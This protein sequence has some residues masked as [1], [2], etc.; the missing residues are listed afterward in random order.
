VA[1]Q[2]PDGG[3]GK[4]IDWL[5]D[6]EPARILELAG[7]RAERSTFDNRN[8]YTQVAYLAEAYRR[9]GEASFRESAERGLGYILREQRPSGGWRGSDIE[10]ITYNDDVMSGI[11]NLLI[12][13]RQGDARFVWLD[14]N[15]RADA[16]DALDRAV[17]VTLACQIRVDGRRTAWCQQHDHETLDAIGARTFELRGISGAESVGIVRTLMR[18]DPS[19]AEVVEAVRAAVAWFRDAALHGIRVES[20]P[21]P[22][23]VLP[24]HTARADKVVVEDPDAPPLWARFYDIE[25]NRPFFADRDGV[26][27]DRLDAIGLERRTGYAWYG[28][29]PGK[30]LDEEYPA[31]EAR[32]GL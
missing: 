11:M 8:V 28:R 27:V 4:N 30:L 25:T 15:L 24:H 7:Q 10:A 9:S 23:Q 29:W 5:L 13:I 18:L 3:W 31:W 19:S 20:V 1:L 16:S 17:A 2:N 21:I 32:L 12:D 26:K 14:E 22:E 6:L